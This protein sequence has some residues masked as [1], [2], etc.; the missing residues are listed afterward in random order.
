MAAER[1]SIGFSGGQV[2]E[3][4]LEDA[5]L[6]DLRKALDKADGWADLDTEE[7]VVSVNLREIVFIRSAATPHS[8]GFGG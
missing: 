1:V 5:K 7:G 6:R 3:V 4:K 2:V 8:I